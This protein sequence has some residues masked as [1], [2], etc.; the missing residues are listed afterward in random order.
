MGTTPRILAFAGSA[1][2]DSLN[3]RLL[4]AAAAAARA[5]GAEVTEHEFRNHPLPLYDGDLEARDGLPEPVRRF[6]ASL[7]AHDGFLIASPE[8]NSSVTPLLK[9]AIDWAS[10]PDGKNPSAAFRGKVAAL[11][12]AS[13]GRLGGLRGLYHLREILQNIG[14]LVVPDVLALP[15]AHQ[16]IAADGALSDSGFA[17]QVEAQAAALVDLLR[18]LRT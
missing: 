3:R 16:A 10:R 7:A 14:V 11:L 4:R 8:Y 6:Q 5:A 1:R 9:N 12:A 18:R 13:P 15:A 17:R 2:A